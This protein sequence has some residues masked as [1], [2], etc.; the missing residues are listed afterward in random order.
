[1]DECEVC[2]KPS[3][4]PS[5]VTFSAASLAERVDVQFCTDCLTAVFQLMAERYNAAVEEGNAAVEEMLRFFKIPADPPA[6]G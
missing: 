1:M 5:V 4:D 6:D 2:L 3:I